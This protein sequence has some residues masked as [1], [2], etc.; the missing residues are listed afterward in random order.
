MPG[1]PKPCG[2]ACGGWLAVNWTLSKRLG[3]YVGRGPGCGAGCD[4]GVVLSNSPSPVLAAG[5]GALGC[6]N[7][8]AMLGSCFC[9]GGGGAA[10]TCCC[11]GAFFLDG[12]ATPLAFFLREIFLGCSS[13]SLS[14]DSS[15]E[16]LSSSSEVDGF[17]F[18]FFFFSGLGSVPLKMESFL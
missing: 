6:S 3:C 11:L 2:C 17:L 1:N 13:S 10:L 9:C 12:L 14:S 4:T 15:S 16:S 18:F 8:S 7:S 5:A